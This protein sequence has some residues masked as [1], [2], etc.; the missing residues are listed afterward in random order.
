MKNISYKIIVFVVLIL[1]I[2]G[3]VSAQEISYGAHIGLGSGNNISVNA[4][5]DL[6]V[7]G[8]RGL[9]GTSVEF[10]LIQ[11]NYSGLIGDGTI[12]NAQLYSFKAY[13]LSQLTL[14]YGDLS[15]YTGPGIEFYGSTSTTVFAAPKTDERISWQLGLSYDIFPM[16]FFVRSSTD[17]SWAASNVGLKGFAISL[18]ASYLL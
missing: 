10:D 9:I 18:G 14:L 5:A 3:V 4:G 12:A 13:L 2:N 11:K 6:R 1:G 8:G 16:Q 17:F 15:I 7:I